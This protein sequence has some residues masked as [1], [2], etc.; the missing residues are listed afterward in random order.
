MVETESDEY[1]LMSKER[2]QSLRV[3][4]INN[5]EI[6]MIVTN[7]ETQQKYSSLVS[8]PK[9]RQLCQIFNT[10]QTPSEALSI[11][12]K[13]IESNGIILIEDLEDNYIE[14][15]YTIKMEGVEY[16][17][18]DINLYM[19]NQEEEKQEEENI[20]K[21]EDVQVLEPIFDYKG[22]IEAQVKYGNT[23]KDTTEFAKPIVQSNVKPP[24]LEIE[25]IEPIVQTHYPDGTTKKTALKP[26]I[27]GPGGQAITE[28][29]VKYIEEQMDTDEIIRNFSPLRDI[30]RN[31]RSNSVANKRRSIYSTQSIPENYN[32]NMMEINP[33]DNAVR[34]ANQATQTQIV[35][36][37]QT[38]NYHN[39][40]TNS[41]NNSFNDFK[42]TTSEYSTMSLPNKPFILPN[43]NYTA[44]FPNPSIQNNGF[45]R[46]NLFHSQ[47]PNQ[48][49]RIIEKRPRMINSNNPRDGVRSSST[50]HEK[51]DE[52]TQN[53][54]IDVYQPNLVYNPYNTI[55][56]EYQPSK[57]KKYPWDRNTQKVSLPAYNTNYKQNLAQDK[58][59]KNQI[60][61]NP[62]INNAQQLKY[63]SRST[64]VAQIQLQKQ[65][66]KEVQDK[67]ALV[68]L[69]Q[70]QIKSKQKE[71]AFQHQQF[72]NIPKRRI[73]HDLL[74]NQT[75]PPILL[76]QQNKNIQKK[77][78][79]NTIDNGP[80]NHNKK[81]KIPMTSK[82]PI[83]QINSLTDNSNFI[84]EHAKTQM[85]G[86]RSQISTPLPTTDNFS[87][88]LLN[89]A[90]MAS[91]QNEIN[92]QFKDLQA[93]TLEEKHQQIQSTE[94]EE[95][96][97]KEYL[98]EKEYQEVGDEGQA[99]ADNANINQNSRQVDPTA[100]EVFITEQ[101]RVIFRNGLLRGIIHR[102]AEIDEVVAKIQDILSKGVKFS[103][104]YKAFDMGDK[105][106]IFHEKCDK[107]KMS[108]VLIETDKDVRFGGF[109][110]RSWEGNCIKK[111]DNNAFVF[112][113]DNNTIYDVIKNEPAIGCYPKFGPVFFGCQ[114]RIYDE[115]FTEGGTTCRKGLNYRTKK[116]FELN[117]GKQNYLI[118]DIEVYNIETVNI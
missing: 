69:Q 112:S 81:K 25:I 4:L 99:F 53:P 95:Y 11:L 83:K 14:L 3:S 63:D 75:N 41:F 45:N 107:L 17:T 39:Y 76:R 43:I 48:N 5:Q 73:N 104:V 46:I 8:L 94:D 27:Q 42:R 40:M 116:D 72:Q 47:N 60:R 88:Q 13:C 7:L 97:P 86:F 51:Y 115:C 44:Q 74:N 37:M 18:F 49:N 21:E 103:L 82:K 93:I 32:Y 68:Q 56:T 96:R 114:I 91:M 79:N 118:K 28:D 33:Y 10:I 22:N 57:V 111:T 64:N 31:N 1:N 9:L 70:Q 108:L 30:L 58:V 12:K 23:S 52:Y 100:E 117:H 55:Q 78:K 84:M 65:R 87:Q 113:L 80:V 19:E 109:T 26:R 89:Y 34:P 66:L 59:P 110:R 50:P 102:Y 20:E 54:N 106:S 24:V 101:G 98:Q 61:A 16:P 92:P 36:N 2:K 71:I 85:S 77:I 15:K 105:A 29:Q 35:N 62:K 38:I 6:L 90:Q 67:L